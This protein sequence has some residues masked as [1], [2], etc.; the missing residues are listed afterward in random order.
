MTRSAQISQRQEGCNI[1]A[2]MKTMYSPDY[3]HNDF[4]ATH[5][6]GDIMYGFLYVYSIV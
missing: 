3:H 4:V 2:I 5:V 1:Y 6:L